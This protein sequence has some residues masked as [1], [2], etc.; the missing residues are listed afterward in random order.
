V[1]DAAWLLSSRGHSLYSETWRVLSAFSDHVATHG[2]E[3][4]AGIWEIRGDNAQH[5]HSKLMAW[6]ALDRAVRLSFSNHTPFASP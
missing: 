4:D 3:P 6:V 2:H 5:V 1:L